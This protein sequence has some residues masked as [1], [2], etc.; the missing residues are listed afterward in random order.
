MSEP[1]YPF[2]GV[3]PAR[4]PRPAAEEPALRGK[5]VV[6]SMP[7]GFVYDMRAASERYENGDAKTVIDIVSEEEWYRWM[8][9]HQQPKRQPFPV[10]L[11]WVE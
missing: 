4:Q 3:P 8:F 5:R 11:V 9:T 7:D 1:H 2:F 10:G 6:L